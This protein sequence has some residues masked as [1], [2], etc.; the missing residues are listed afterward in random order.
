[1]NQ[2][3]RSRVG[4]ADAEKIKDDLALRLRGAG[5][6]CLAEGEAR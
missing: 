5:C 6:R 1:M 4:G 3:Q 2:Q